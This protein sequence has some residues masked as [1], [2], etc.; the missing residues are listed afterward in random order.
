MRRLVVLA[1]GTWEDADFQSNPDLL[2]NVGRLARAI[3][4]TDTRSGQPVPQIIRYAE[5]LGT[6]STALVG[7]YQ[8]ARGIGLL[9]KTRHLYD[10]LCLNYE[11]DAEIT[12]VGFSRGAYCVRLLASLIGQIGLLMPSKMHLFP[13]IFDALC[14]KW[15]LEESEERLRLLL[16]AN[17]EDRLAQLRQC[18][19]GFLIKALLVFDTVP[20]SPYNERSGLSSGDAPILWNAFGM[21]AD[22][23]EPHIE[24]ALQALA[25]NESR[26]AYKPLLFQVDPRNPKQGQ[27]LLQTWFVGAH[28]DIGGGYQD[29]DLADISLIWSVERL[30]RFAGLSFDLDYL[31][32]ITSHPTSM[33][34]QMQPHK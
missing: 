15:E 28:T 14:A 21:Q 22:R 32:E 6:G 31:D 19:N 3:H 9:A 13:E 25:I 7:A 8:G 12:L 29:H 33:W 17:E 26:P 23:L 1:D 10:W 24:T 20:V 11:K 16:E 4:T 2:T 34:G 27:T 18:P 5:G 30:M